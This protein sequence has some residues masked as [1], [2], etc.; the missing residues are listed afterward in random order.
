MGLSTFSTSCL[1]ISVS[2]I[3][4]VATNSVPLHTRQIICGGEPGFRCIKRDLNLELPGFGANGSPRKKARGGPPA[5]LL[6]SDPH[7]REHFARSSTVADIANLSPA[8]K[9]HIYLT[10]IGR[11]LIRVYLLKA[12]QYMIGL[13]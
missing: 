13:A 12:S 3:L 2:R 7:I 8:A 4:K 9:R 10:K 11:F 6:H 1:F 5:R